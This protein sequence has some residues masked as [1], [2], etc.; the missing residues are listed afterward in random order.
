MD[1]VVYILGTV[2]RAHTV[3]CIVLQCFTSVMFAQFLCWRGGS[4]SAL[5]GS[6]AMPVTLQQGCLPACCGGCCW[7]CHS[8]ALTRAVIP[9]SASHR[10]ALRKGEIFLLLLSLTQTSRGHRIAAHYWSDAFLFFLFLNTAPIKNVEPPASLCVRGI[11]WTGQIFSQLPSNDLDAI[12]TPCGV[13]TRP[14]FI[15]ISQS[16]GRGGTACGQLR[17]EWGKWH[18]PKCPVDAWSIIRALHETVV[19]EEPWAIEHT[20]AQGCLFKLAC[21][22]SVCRAWLLLHSFN[23]LM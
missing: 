11:T 12:L 20:S 19:K 15:V 17:F 2:S 8:E 22:S 6:C 23:D 13:S 7:Y 10:D 18:D 21:S 1:C 16:G 9:E 5:A 14:Y 4:V 3:A